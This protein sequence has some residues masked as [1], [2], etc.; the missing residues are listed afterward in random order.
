[1]AGPHYLC[2]K[3]QE[4]EAMKNKGRLIIIGGREDKEK[5]RTILKEIARRCDHRLVLTTVASDIAD[6]VWEDYKKVFRDLGVKDIVHLDINSIE[7]ARDPERLKLLHRAS[8]VFFSGGDQLKITTR[9]GGTPI[10]DKILELYRDGATIAGTSA[11]ASV[12]SA[13]MLTGSDDDESHKIGNLRMAPGL[14]FTREMIIDQHFAQRGRIGRLLGAVALN[15]GV[16][17]VGIDE[18]TCIIVDDTGFDVI[19]SNAVYVVDGHEVKK[20]NVTEAEKYKT[21]TIYGVKL[22]VLGDCDSFEFE[23]REPVIYESVSISKSS[24]KSESKEQAHVN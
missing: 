3:S 15:P 14:G 1:M 6:E 10:A 9:I 2:Q 17:G 4:V 12:M 11:G 23:T 21:M 20:T 18:D 7:D 22:H 24:S 19:G 8:V 13:T 16:L 5:D